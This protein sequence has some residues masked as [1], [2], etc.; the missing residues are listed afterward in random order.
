[1]D[2]QGYPLDETKLQGEKKHTNQ[3]YKKTMNITERLGN[4]KKTYKSLTCCQVNLRTNVKITN[5]RWFISKT[6]SR[7][8]IKRS[9]LPSPKPHPLVA[10]PIVDFSYVKK[11]PA[12]QIRIN[13]FLRNHW[14]CSCETQPLP[15]QVL[16][17][18]PSSI[19]A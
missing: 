4:I 2:F 1:V 15:H 10:I 12:T 13:L 7:Q 18:N 19:I 6:L 5:I 8:T 11:N 14:S 17:L 9:K 3:T 16:N